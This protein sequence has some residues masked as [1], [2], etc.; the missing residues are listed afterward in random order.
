MPPF[1]KRN[2]NNLDINI[3]RTEEEEQYPSYT[4]TFNIEF[5]HSDDA[6]YIAHCYPYTYSDL[7]EYLSRLQ[8]H[9]VKSMYSKLRLLCR[10]LAGNNV[11]YLTITAPQNC[12]EMEQKVCETIII[13][14]IT[15][16]ILLIIFTSF[17]LTCNVCLFMW[18]LATQF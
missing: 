17:H 18:N 2:S 1:I 4:L 7:Q 9:P 6:V 8:A 3:Y 14:N 16:E 11:Y 10:T 13:L 5:P 15:L 12:N